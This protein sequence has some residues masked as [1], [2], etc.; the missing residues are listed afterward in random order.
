MKT[1]QLPRC[2]LLYSAVA[3]AALGGSVTAFAQEGRT[4][5]EVVVTA[6]K[7]AESMQEVP[8]A[9]TAVTG[10]AIANQNITNISGLQNAIP[11]V[12]I[13]TFSN[14][15]D[16]AV[17]TIRGVGVNDADPYV[18]TTVSVVV[19]G[20]VV[21][22]NT[23]ALL[24]LFD[25]ERVEILRGPQGTL[26]GANTT[27]GVINVVTKQPTGDYSGEAQI[28]VGNYG[29]LDANVAVNFPITDNLAGKVSILHTGHDGF[30]KN[31][32][33]GADLGGRDITS[34]RGYLQYTSGNYDAT[35]I[36][37]YVRSRNGSQPGVSFAEPGMVFHIPGYND[38]GRIRHRR[39]LSAGVPDQND[40][41]TYSLTLTQNITTGWGDVVSITNYREYDHDLYSDDD[42][43]ELQL[44]HTRRQT[45]H[46]QISQELRTTFDLTEDLQLL[47]GGFAFYQDYELKQDGVLDG[48]MP[49][50]GQ[51]QTQEQRNWSGSLFA[52]MY[53]DLTD[54]LRFQAGLRYTHEDTKG[55]ST[56]ANTMSPDGS[57]GSFNDPI[58]PGSLVVASGDKSWD[59]VGGKIGLDYQLTD[60]SMLYGYYARGFKSGGFVG[61]IIIPEDIGPFDT[62]YLDT[63]EV[64]I[65]SDLFDNRVRLNLALFYNEYDDMQVTQNITLPSGANSAS[66]VNAGEATSQGAELEL[67]AL[68]TDHLTFNMGLA[69]LDAKY[70]DYETLVSDGL[71]GLVPVNF[72]GN[73]LM[74][75]PRWSGNANATYEIPMGPGHAKFFLQ[76]THSSPK[77][78]AFTGL[79][80]EKIGDIT[81]VNANV[82]WTPDDER[83]SIGLYGRNLTDKTYYG[84][85]LYLSG[86][87]ALASV[88]DPREYGVDFKYRW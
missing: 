20:V 36:G 23:A 11:N 52:Q 17:F 41:D 32:L 59:N 4:L 65:K 69:Y 84:Q 49:G 58:I 8:I 24:S 1:T 80:Q 53:W 43:T 56:T 14:S 42:A 3:L 12:Q 27:G 51:P 82:S 39:G 5:E 73:H 2:R 21:G 16:S 83:W 40:R 48:F 18:G 30:F 46:Y 87:V 70:E 6:Q 62:E 72:K 15:P 50:L 55:T 85:V 57:P 74:N 25:I 63:I 67:T 47:V 75:A 68:L 13:N 66:I 79:P 35:L 38:T 61:R 76:M 29:R 81:L 88:A 19:D 7:R 86:V 77:Y 64:G 26:F 22:V 34:L 60:S 45:E 28:T 78:T 37:E 9:M 10:D 44:L 54:R 31:T 71:G 33:N